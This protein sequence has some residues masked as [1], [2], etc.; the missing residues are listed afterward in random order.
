MV[1]SDALGLRT[2]AEHVETSQQL[3]LL[4]ERGCHLAQGYL[5]AP[6]LPAAEVPVRLPLRR[7]ARMPS[8]RL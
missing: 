7:A 5:F 8:T 2:V 6:A 1:I 4:R 3:A